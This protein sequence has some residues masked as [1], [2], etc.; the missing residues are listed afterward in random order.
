MEFRF[1][2]S[3]PF[4]L[5]T[6]LFLVGLIAS[7]WIKK[8]PLIWGTGLGIYAVLTIIAGRLTLVPWL[9]LGVSCISYWYF[10]RAKNRIVKAVSLVSFVAASAV[11]LLH[12]VPGT[13]NWKFLSEFRLSPN[14]L[15][16][17]LYLNYDA[18]VVGFFMLAIGATLI[19][20]RKEWWRILQTVAPIS[21]AVIL[22]MIPA[23]L[24]LG[25]VTFDPKTTSIFFVW[26]IT[27][28]LFTCVTEEAIFRLFIQTTFIRWFSKF[29]YGWLWGIILA[30]FC[31]GL[32]HLAGGPLYVL[33]AS[34]AGLFYGYAYYKTQRIEASILTHFI[35][36]AFHFLLFTYP[37]LESAIK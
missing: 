34:I 27:N 10:V 2:L 19:S 12:Q 31:F 23:S 26:A 5:F 18:P 21:V 25:Y 11:V 30:S 4:S 1:F 15:P 33:L 37:A 14:A 6:S 3:D 17:S 35:L 13:T 29:K 22:F 28:L 24:A 36:N 9:I 16:L 7:L 8:S 32:A 20:T